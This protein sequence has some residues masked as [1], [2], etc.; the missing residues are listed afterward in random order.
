M[1]ITTPDASPDELAGLWV[2]LAESQR[3]HDSHIQPAAN[4]PRIRQAIAEHLVQ[5]RVLVAREDG[6][7][8]GFVMYTIERPAYNQDVH[9]GVVENLYVRPERRSEG[10]GSALLEAAEDALADQGLDAITLEVMARNDGARRFYRRAG[11][12]VRR[13]Q[14]EKSLG[15]DTTSRGDE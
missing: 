10:I 15:T 14:L 4:R 8:L 7:V 11:Y 1:E 5:D 2:D 9:R 13:V 3:G 6:E 12:E